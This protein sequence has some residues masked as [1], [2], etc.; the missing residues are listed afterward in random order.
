[1]TSRWST[2]GKEDAE[3]TA[4]Q[5]RQK[6]EKRKRKDERRETGRQTEGRHQRQVEL[7]EKRQRVISSEPEDSGTAVAVATESIATSIAETSGSFDQYTILNDIAEGQ[8]GSVSRAQA[9][10]TGSIVALKKVK[11]DSSRTS[12]FSLTALREIQLLRDCDHDHILHLH[13]V[14]TDKSLQE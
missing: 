6:R 12:S 9:K 14:V 7:S 2:N 4:E 3:R 8:Y 10:N 1:M 11:R 13:E 5:Q